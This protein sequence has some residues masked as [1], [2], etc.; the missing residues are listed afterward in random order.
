MSKILLFL[1]GFYFMGTAHAMMPI[2]AETVQAAQQYGVSQKNVSTERIVS[3]VDS[4]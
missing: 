2:T 3:W 1:A 4:C